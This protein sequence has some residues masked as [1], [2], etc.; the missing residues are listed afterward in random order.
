MRRTLAILLCLLAVP[1]PSGAGQGRAVAA[2]AMTVSDLD[3]SASFYTRVLGFK[4]E[5]EVEVAGSEYEHLEG[6][7]GLRMRV[8]SCG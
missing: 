2:V 8:S 7:F 4:S 6:V 3:R 5:S 1:C